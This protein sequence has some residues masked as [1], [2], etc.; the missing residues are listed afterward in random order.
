MESRCTPSDQRALTSDD[1]TSGFGGISSALSGQVTAQSSLT[2]SS[3]WFIVDNPT[4]INL[5]T[6]TGER[7][8][9]EE[10]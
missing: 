6:K 4:K 5:K 8:K 1:H 7:G 2:A 3:K 9:R 10:K